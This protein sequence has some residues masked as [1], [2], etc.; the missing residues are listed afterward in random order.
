MTPGSN[1]DKI[2]KNSL[3]HVEFTVKNCKAFAQYQT[4]LNNPLR[5]C[6]WRWLNKKK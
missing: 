2:G 3:C 6:A 4:K 1:A 5:C